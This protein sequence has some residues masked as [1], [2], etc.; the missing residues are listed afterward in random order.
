M[1]LK[2][3]SKIQVCHENLFFKEEG[4][5][6]SLWLCL[7]Q[8]MVS[9]DNWGA[10]TFSPFCGCC[11]TLLSGCLG[12]LSCRQDL[13]G[14]VSA[15]L[16]EPAQSEEPPGKHGRC[17]ATAGAHPWGWW[18]PRREAVGGGRGWGLWPKAGVDGLL[19]KGKENWA[20]ALLLCYFCSR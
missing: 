2:I 1:D 15:V 12:T 14:T 9:V 5:K 7:I 17:G 8:K 19:Q 20:A 11:V 6:N 10:V 13:L 4:S 16:A 18:W 3:M